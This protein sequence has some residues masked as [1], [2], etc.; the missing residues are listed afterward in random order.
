MLKILSNKIFVLTVIFILLISIFSVY[1]VFFFEEK[2]NESFLVDVQNSLDLAEGWLTS[3]MKDK[4]CF[5][6]VYDPSDDEYSTSNNMIRQLMGSR[7]LAE[8]SQDDVSLQEMHQKNLDFIFEYW[9]EEDGEIGYIYY[10][11]KS[12]LGAMAMALRTLVFSPFFDNYHDEVTK[13]V[14]CI[15]YLQNEDGSLEPWY[16]EPDYGYDHDYLLTFYSGEAILALVDYYIKTNNVTV[17]NAAILSQDYYVTRYVDQLDDNYYPAY[18]PWHTQSLNKLYK[19]TENQVYADAIMTLNDELLIIQ[20]TENSETLG[21]FYNPDYSEYGSP[22]SSSD[23]VYTEGLAYAYEIADIINDE[24]HKQKYREAVVLGVYNIISL[25]Y[26]TD[27]TGDLL[28]PEKV[29]G[30]I[31]YGI[32]DDR[33]RIDT[34]QHTMDAYMKI[35]LVFDE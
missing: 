2:E 32:K 6:Y 9:Y 3:N 30:A 23:G 11:D 22:H 21:R 17:L 35:L 29:I 24:N 10:S 26:T 1:L 5:N 19:I 15:L 4:G 25:Q 18:V 13:L 20:D 27:N 14:N 16:I 12:K 33:I 34:T 28:F 31:K 8:L 7:V